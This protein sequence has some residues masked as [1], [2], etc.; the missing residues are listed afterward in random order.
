MPD[1]PLSPEEIDRELDQLER[2]GGG[3]PDIERLGL[4]PLSIAHLAEM[5]V[6]KLRVLAALAVALAQSDVEPFFDDRRLLARFLAILIEA[7]DAEKG[8]IVT[9]EG[10]EGGERLVTLAAR[11]GDE[12]VGPEAFSLTLVRRVLA[13]GSLQTGSGP[14]EADETG[15]TESIVLKVGGPYVVLPL[16]APRVVGKDGAVQAAPRPFAAVFLVRPLGAPSFDGELPLLGLVS[17]LTAPLIHRSRLIRDL[18]SSRDSVAAEKRALEAELESLK[19]RLSGES[20]YARIVGKRSPRMLRCLERV[21]PAARSVQPVLITGESGAG[22]ELMAR[23]IHEHPASP[24]ARG[25]FVTVNC[26]AIPD[27]LIESELFG[28]ER[29]AFTGAVRPREGLFRAAHGGTIFLDEITETSAKLQTGLLR[30]LQEGVVRPVGATREVAVDVRVI[31]AT[32]R[33]VPLEIGAGRFREDLYYRLNVV[34]LEVPALRE[35][36]EDIP[37]LALHFLK[38]AGRAEG[39]SDLQGFTA[40]AL[41]AL[42]GHRWPGNVRQLENLVRQAVLFAKGPRINVRDLRLRS[43]P[44]EESG[45]TLEATMH[46]VERTLLERALAEAGGNVTHVARQL[47]IHR[48]YVYMLAKK[49]GIRLSR[50]RDG[51]E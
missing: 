3:V 43:D 33:D 30:V 9:V 25:P 13:S 2:D 1:A 32:N 47:G 12:T 31:A 14:H 46:V 26:G 19:E 40:P 28:H 41:A 4:R 27:T 42:V 51:S 48:S 23:A 10:D 16:V 21:L 7:L 22:K 37:E 45:E 49:H 44:G 20:T 17:E 35:R 50:R 34:S 38:D 39:R 18:Q 11:I 36:R 8:A 24:R 29:G 15:L 5:P 6:A